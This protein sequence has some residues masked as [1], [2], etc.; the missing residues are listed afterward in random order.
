MD[1]FSPI[2]RLISKK[3]GQSRKQ[4]KGQPDLRGTLMT[5][6]A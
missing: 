6:R 4:P 2:A 1:S 3:K 5:I